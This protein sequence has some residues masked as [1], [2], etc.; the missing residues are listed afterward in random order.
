M[1]RC[2]LNYQADTLCFAT[3]GPFNATKDPVS[4]SKSPSPGRPR[5]TK[6]DAAV[7]VVLGLSALACSSCATLSPDEQA[8]NS[9][10]RFQQEMQRPTEPGKGR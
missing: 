9:E 5:F 8:D 10:T 7:L 4:A 2:D 6:A 1:P 3:N